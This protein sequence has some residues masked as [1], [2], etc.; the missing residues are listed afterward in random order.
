MAIVNLSKFQSTVS[1]CFSI[2]HCQICLIYCIDS[3]THF[4]HIC[5][6]VIF[7]FISCFLFKYWVR[8]AILICIE[9]SFWIDQHNHSFETSFQQSWDN[10]I[11]SNER[12]NIEQEISGSEIL[13]DPKVLQELTLLE[14][15]TFLHIVL[16]NCLSEFLKLSICWLCHL[17]VFKNIHMLLQVNYW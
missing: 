10:Y 11:N 16:Q 2:L 4:Y 13:M 3:T 12:K 8:L 9:N 17:I 15:E 5:W 14:K 7:F 6:F 1:F